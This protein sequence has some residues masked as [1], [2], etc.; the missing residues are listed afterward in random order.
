MSTLSRY[1]L[2][3][4][5]A[6]NL[7]LGAGLVWLLRAPPP[8]D[9]PPAM[10]RPDALRQALSPQRSALV[11][12]VAARHREAM[13]AR[14]GRIHQARG[15]VREALRAEPFERGALDAAFERLREAESGAATEAHALLADLASEA[16]PADRV[17]L[18]Q[19]M[20]HRHDRRRQSRERGR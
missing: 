17:R 19:L 16:S 14:I 6:L 18:A 11:E 7:V 1:L 15:E 9:S 8:P 20:E 13:R 12:T 4:S 10:F 3:A 5:L 2:L